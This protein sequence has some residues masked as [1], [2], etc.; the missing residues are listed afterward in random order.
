MCA[1]DSN[2]MTFSDSRI[3]SWTSLMKRRHRCDVFWLKLL[4]SRCLNSER[5]ELFACSKKKSLNSLETLEMVEMQKE[6][7]EQRLVA[8]RL[9]QTFGPP[10]IRLHKHTP[11][12]RYQSS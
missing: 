11:P 1:I 8:H 4:F 9:F 5:H 10:V 12:C 6:D 2:L 7:G 3:K